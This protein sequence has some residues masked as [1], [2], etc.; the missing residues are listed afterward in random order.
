[1]FARPIHWQSEVASTNDVASRLAVA[2]A[3]EGTVVAADTQ[4]AGRGRL[5]RAWSSPPGAGLY[6][7][8]VLRPAPA[9]VPLLTIAAGVAIADGI[10][11]ASGLGMA[12]KWP[13]DLYVGSRKAGGILAEAGTSATGVSHVVVGFGVNL[14]PAAYPQEIAARATSLEVELGRPVDRGLALASC[15]AALAR[16]Y[17]ELRHGQVAA[18]LTTWT[19]YAATTLNRRVECVRAAGPVTGIAEGIDGTGAL[20]VRTGTTV[21]RVISGEVTWP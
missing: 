16:Q 11:E 10:R 8:V 6:V 12:L 1:M 15:L 2:V 21:I 4:T 9:M 17:D 5:G 19:S 3:P 7:S 18:L 20:L 13:N 14:S